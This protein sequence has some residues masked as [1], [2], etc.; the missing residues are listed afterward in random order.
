[1]YKGKAIGGP[2]DG[3]QM[4]HSVKT[5]QMSAADPG[6]VFDGPKSNEAALEAVTMKVGTYTFDTATETWKWSE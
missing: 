6:S 5:W 4:A 3:K 1:M 2:H